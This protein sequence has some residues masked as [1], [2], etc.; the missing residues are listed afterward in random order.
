MPVSQ[1]HISDLKQK[2]QENAL[3]VDKLAVALKE[4]ESLKEPN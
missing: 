4:I 1:S 2:E 3:L